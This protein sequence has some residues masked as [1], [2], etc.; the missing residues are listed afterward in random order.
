MTFIKNLIIGAGPAG[1]AVAGRMRNA[2]MEFEILEQSQNVGN[3]WHN[4]YDRL[5]LHTVKQYS[6]LPL[7]EFPDDYPTYVSRKQLT[8]YF[9]D[10]AAKFNISPRFGEEVTVIKKNENGNENGKWLI[11]TKKGNKYS[12][13]NVVIATGVNR[14]P[15]V[16]KFKG[17]ENFQGKIVHSHLYKNPQ[18]FFKPARVGYRDGKHRS[19]N[20]T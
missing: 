11:E 12:A 19:R 15:N 10:Y 20:C 1:L 9:D 17:Q 2:E 5:H 4:H 7:M 14:I 3:A 18:P 13:E 6:Y 8:K 16:P